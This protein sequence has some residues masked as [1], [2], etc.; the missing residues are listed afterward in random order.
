MNHARAV[1]PVH[2]ATS[3]NLTRDEAKNVHQKTKLFSVK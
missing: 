3:I 1:N 2:Y